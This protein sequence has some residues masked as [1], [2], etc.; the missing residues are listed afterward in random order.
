M[1]F[2]ATN[3]RAGISLLE[4]LIIL[5][6]ILF[7]FALL[8]P[9]LARARQAA[10]QSQSHNNLRQL[11]IAM[12]NI[13][14]TH[15]RMPPIAGPFAGMP[16]GTVHFFILPYLEQDNIYRNAKGNVTRVYGTVIPTF[17]HPKDTQAPAGN[18]FRDWLAT[19][20]YAAN[21]MLL[22]TTGAQLQQVTDGTS[23]TL[24]FAERYQLCKD[25]PCAWGYAQVYTWA[26]MF[27]Y[28]S[29]AKFQMQPKQE[30]C[31]PT[32]AQAIEQD[33]I[34]VAMCDGSSRTLPPTM[35]T[36]TWALLTHPSDGNVLPNDF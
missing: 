18:K 27:G 7:L 6:I 11:A 3:R 36:R 14:D 1:F 4:I 34:A 35:S 28:Y 26:P 25:A 30:E 8:V 21:W 17:L 22:R 23:N 29:Q 15:M 24:M 9:L 33:G 5:G 31:D 10:A 2:R 12:H 13:H 16:N 19:T 32:L 20:N